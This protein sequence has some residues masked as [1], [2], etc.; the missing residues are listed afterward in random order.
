MPSRIKYQDIKDMKP[1]EAYDYLCALE[2]TSVKDMKMRELLNKEAL[3][4][5]IM[6]SFFRDLSPRGV[7]LF[8]TPQGH[9]SYVGKTTE[10]FY[11]RI[12]IQLDPGSYSDRAYNNLL[13]KMGTKRHNVDSSQ[14]EEEHLYDD[15]EELN[16]YR[17]LMIDAGSKEE[18]DDYLVGRL[19]RILL[20]MVNSIDTTAF[21]NTGVAYLQDH[22]W[23]QTI[24]QILY[25]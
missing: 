20:W 1:Q 14:L 12:L 23:E 22:H 17:L 13:L 24:D 18:F 4:K 15:L 6:D 9:I 11:K 7:Y 5:P 2:K 19:E 8:F 25:E 16:N 3:D 10:S 21:L